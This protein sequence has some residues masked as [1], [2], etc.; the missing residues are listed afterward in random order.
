MEKLKFNV[1]SLIKI[2]LSS[3]SQNYAAVSLLPHIELKVNIIMWW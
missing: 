3:A 1:L 2:S